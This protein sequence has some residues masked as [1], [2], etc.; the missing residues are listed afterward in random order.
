MLTNASGHWLK[1]YKRKYFLE[2][3]VF[4]FLKFEKVLSLKLT[5]FFLSTYNCL[6]NAP[7][8]STG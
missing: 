7:P 6:T 3:C 1:N 4:Y 5:L 8:Q 2:N